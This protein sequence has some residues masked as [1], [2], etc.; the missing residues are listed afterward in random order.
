MTVLDLAKLLLEKQGWTH[1][2]LS[3][4]CGTSRQ[5]IQRLISGKPRKKKGF[6]IGVL[7]AAF[8]YG[9][10]A[11][12]IHVIT[13]STK[14]LQSIVRAVIMYPDI[15]QEE[16]AEIREAEKITHM[17]SLPIEV[18]SSIVTANRLKKNKK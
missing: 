1:Q 12:A 8:R 4:E 13:G 10:E 18:I 17:Y 14:V 15:T 7:S 16:L 3:K 2:R 11:E 6:Y 9:L 5:N